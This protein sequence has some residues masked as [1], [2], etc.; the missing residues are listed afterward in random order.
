[1]RKQIQK[2]VLYV[3]L[4]ILTLLVVSSSAQAQLSPSMSPWLEMNRTGNTSPL[5]NYL[6]IV[7]PMQEAA[8]ANAATASAIQSNER[9]L[10]AMQ[11]SAGGGAP[12]TLG[13]AG[14]SAPGGGISPFLE[15]PREIPSRLNPAGF[16]QYLHYYPN[17]NM[18]RRP[19][20]NF[21]RPGRRG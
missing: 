11:D 9:A 18:Q 8:R 19:V 10:A 16:D 21:S 7:R 15:P 12:L 4:V 2:S 14:R 6:G 20:P 5:G 3:S 17:A 1:M 13:G